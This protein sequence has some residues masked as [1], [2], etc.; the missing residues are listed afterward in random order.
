MHEGIHAYLVLFF[1]NDITK[2][3]IDFAD[4]V[5]EFD[6]TKDLNSTHHEEFVHKFSSNIS[7]SLQEY[8]ISKGYNLTK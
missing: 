6:K 2:A 4:L 1:A 5:V 3:N 8:G 7:I